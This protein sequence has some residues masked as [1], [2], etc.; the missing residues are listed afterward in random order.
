[1]YSIGE[2]SKITG[3]S[4]KTL[5][6]Y[7]E[8]GVLLP[9]CIDDETGYRY[10][11]AGS[12]EKARVV[13]RLREMEFS[14]NQIKEMLECAED[15]ADILDFLEA[16]QAAIAERIRHYRNVTDSLQQIISNEREAR[17]AMKGA[18][19]EVQEKDVESVLIAGIRMKGKYSDCGKGFAKIGKACGRHIR[20][21]PF[22]LYYDGEYREED[23]DLEACFPIRKRVDAEGISVRELQGGHCVTLLHRGPWYE[24]GRS[25]AKIM[26][27]VKQ[28][29]YEALLP[30][31]EV[32]LKG[33]GMI[34]RGNPKKYLTEIQILVKA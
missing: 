29:D 14:L 12:A 26:D 4:V 13:A 27:Y 31:R 18:G 30:Y 10:Y 19:F 16:Q 24:L 28:K 17:M 25:Y 7:H 8:K 2:F 23:A 21:K 22:N 33:P 5:R 1:M 20:G 15:E 6:F 9:P 32:Y 11:D 3:L 34:F